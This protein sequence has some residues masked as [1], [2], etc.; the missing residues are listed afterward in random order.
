LS[1]NKFDIRDRVV[2]SA[3]E[4]FYKQA[5]ARQNQKST[6]SDKEKWE[7]F[8]SLDKEAKAALRIESVNL[9]VYPK[10]IGLDF[11]EV[12]TL[13]ADEAPGYTLMI[14]L[15]ISRFVLLLNMVHR[16]R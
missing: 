16:L 12:V 9:Q 5:I 13:Q 7:I 10:M 11:F 4:E 1:E 3:N 14:R 6:K 8:N 2:T 15:L